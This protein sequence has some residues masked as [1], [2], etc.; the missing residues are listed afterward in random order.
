M[1]MNLWNYGEIPHQ[2]GSLVS[3]E[4]FG[5]WVVG[6]FD[7]LLWN[8][9]L[10]KNYFLNVYVHREPLWKQKSKV[11]TYVPVFIQAGVSETLEIVLRYFIS[12]P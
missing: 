2:I 11:L 7:L 9:P 3:T 8:K 4:I 10:F 12:V 5:R 1:Y 6:G